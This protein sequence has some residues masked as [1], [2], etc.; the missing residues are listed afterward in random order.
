MLKEFTFFCRQKRNSKRK[1]TLLA[2]TGDP[3]WLLIQVSILPLLTKAV[4]TRLVLHWTLIVLYYVL[5][6]NQPNKP[7]RKFQLHC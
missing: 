5:K 3:M 7:E 4:T 6:K 2:V 1:S